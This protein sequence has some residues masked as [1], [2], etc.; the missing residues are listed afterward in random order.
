M[1]S[2]QTREGREQAATGLGQD[3]YEAFCSQGKFGPW[4]DGGGW[5][6]KWS[7]DVPRAV[8]C[9]DL[10]QSLDATDIP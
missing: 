9:N 6:R 8:W 5:G 10:G 2:N 3:E 1:G 4:G 7:E